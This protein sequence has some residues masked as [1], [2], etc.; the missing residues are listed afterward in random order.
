MDS[1]GARRAIVGDVALGDAESKAMTRRLCCD[2]ESL[3][4]CLAAFGS[5]ALRTQIK[6]VNCSI[7]GCLANAF[8][9]SL[10][11]DLVA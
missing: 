6:V 7:L 11:A 4:R 5:A 9:R 8:E 3:S 2:F 10:F 1:M